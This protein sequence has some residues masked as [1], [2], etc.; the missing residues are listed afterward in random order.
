MP[1]VMIGDLGAERIL[2]PA[3]VRREPEGPAAAL[4]V[5]ARGG[6]GFGGG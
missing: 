1:I 4:G 6:L 5:S 3:P 2:E